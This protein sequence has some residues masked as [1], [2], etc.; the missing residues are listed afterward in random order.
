MDVMLVSLYLADVAEMHSCHWF[1][2][3]SAKQHPEL[4]KANE[5]EKSLDSVGALAEIDLDFTADQ[6]DGL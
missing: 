3:P 4:G 5:S 6:N 1:N 2:L